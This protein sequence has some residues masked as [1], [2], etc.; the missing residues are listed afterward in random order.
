MKRSYGSGRLFVVKHKGGG[1]SWYGSWW[2]GPVRVKR[3]LGPKRPAG[4]SGGMVASAG[5]AVK[6]WIAAHSGAIGPPAHKR[7]SL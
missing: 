4:S 3:K 2:A 1:E 6:E 7:A 5:R